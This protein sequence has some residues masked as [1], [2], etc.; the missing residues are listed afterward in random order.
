MRFFKALWHRLTGVI[1]DRGATC[2]KCG[3]NNTDKENNIW[4]CYDCGHE[5]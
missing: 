2:P 1:Q 5:W 4:S 3:S